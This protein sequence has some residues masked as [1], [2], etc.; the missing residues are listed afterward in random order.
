M[1]CTIRFVSLIFYQPSLDEFSFA[2]LCWARLVIVCLKVLKKE[3]LKEMKIKEGA[4]KLRDVSTDKKSL[5]NV[6]S[7]VKKA[8]IKLQQLHDSLQ[9]LN[10]CLL[11]CDG[12]QDVCAG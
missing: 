11:V 10:D 6:N 12:P 8:N 2:V 9:D 4:K 1:L 5:A 3:V 7:I